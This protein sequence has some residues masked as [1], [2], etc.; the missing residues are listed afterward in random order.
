MNVL[1][2]VRMN[3]IKLA[4]KLS[5]IKKHCDLNLKLD[6]EMVGFMDRNN[7]DPLSKRDM[8]KAIKHYDKIKYD[9]E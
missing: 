3:K 8:I 4:L 5:K 6:N 1:I 7:L 9:Y 2:G